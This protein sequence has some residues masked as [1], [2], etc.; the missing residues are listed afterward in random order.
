MNLPKPDRS[1]TSPNHSKSAENPVI[2]L[3]W[4]DGL[5]SDSR[6]HCIAA[7]AEDQISVVT[8]FMPAAGIETHANQHVADLLERDEIIAYRPRRRRSAATMPVTDAR[9]NSVWSV[10]VVTGADEDTFVDVLTV[11]RPHADVH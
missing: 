4:G 9:G 2:E 5:L 3:G 10:N 6:P 11:L 1:E 8:A 7:W